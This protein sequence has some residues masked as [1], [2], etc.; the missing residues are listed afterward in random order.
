MPVSRHRKLAQEIFMDKVMAFASIPERP[1]HLDNADLLSTRNTV[2]SKLS[3][4][5]PKNIHVLT[6]E[7]V[8]RSQIL[9]RLEHFYERAED[10]TN[11][12]AVIIPIKSIVHALPFVKNCKETA[13]GGNQWIEKVKRFEWTPKENDPLAHYNLQEGDDPI[14]TTADNVVIKPMEI[15]TFLCS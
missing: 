6:L 1:G 15:K 7:P 13:L 11:S 10:P 14:V 8:S 5:L 4:I 9:L 12:E 2:M 3:N